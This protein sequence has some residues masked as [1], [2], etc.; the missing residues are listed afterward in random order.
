MSPRIPKASPALLLLFA[1]TWASGQNPVYKCGAT[2]LYTDKPCDDASLVDLTKQ[3]NV[4]APGPTYV[5][6]PPPE[7][8]PQP[9]VI[10]PNSSRIVSTPA[11]PPSTIWSDRDSRQASPAP[12]PADAGRRGYP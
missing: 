1:A 4:L 10:W 6:P 12:T 3:D 5:P 9:A 2:P 11:A 8:T 7:P